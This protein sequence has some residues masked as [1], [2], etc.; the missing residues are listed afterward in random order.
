MKAF[1]ESGNIC[2]YHGDAREI[3]PNLSAE[4]VITDPVWPNSTPELVGANRPYELF[5]EVARLLPAAVSRVVVQL[6]C[7]S[8]PRMLFGMPS[9]L[10]FF[11][12]CH[13][14]YVRPHYKG[15]LLYTHDVAYVFGAPPKSKKGAHV[16]PGRVLQKDAAK[17]FAGHPCPRQSAHVKWLVHWFG[18]ESVIDPF[19]GSGTTLLAA[20]MLGV[21]AVGVEISEEYCE[22]AAHRLD[23]AP[24]ILE[25]AR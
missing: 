16:M 21:K 22:A 12:A 10:R 15:R 2:L 9:E 20:Q 23:T 5:A 17:R 14:E 13:L 8:D 24:L 25:V 4:S 11:R 7:D 19:C 6:G 18:G 1:Y 3:L